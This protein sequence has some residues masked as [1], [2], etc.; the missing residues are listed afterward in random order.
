MRLNRGQSEKDLFLV[1]SEATSSRLMAVEVFY[2]VFGFWWSA[3]HVWVKDSCSW[4]SELCS[5]SKAHCHCTGRF[6]SAAVIQWCL[7]GMVL[8]F[9]VVLHS[10]GVKLTKLQGKHACLYRSCQGSDLVSGC[11]L[12]N[13]FVEAWCSCGLE[14]L[15]NGSVLH[16]WSQVWE[17]SQ[18]LDW[19]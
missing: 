3:R 12:V 4:S 2:R 8:V 10:W 13:L 1:C 19:Y 6:I 11:V 5:T 14:L 15:K 16:S 7:F 18:K 17:T 9:L